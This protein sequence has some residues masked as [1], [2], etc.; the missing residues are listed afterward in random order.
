MTPS[1]KFVTD[2]CENTFL[3]FWSFPNPIGKRID[4]EL[5]DILVICDP[6]III[7]SV[8][9]I[10]VKE[11]GNVGVDHQ[12]WERNAIQE[13]VKQI[14]GAERFL[15]QKEDILLKDRIT[16]IKLPEK[17]IRNIYRV[18][19]AFGR[20][21]KFSLKMGD[22]GK[23][24]VHVFDERS[25]PIILQELDTITDF[26]DFLKAKEEFANK[27]IYHIAFSG[28]DYLAMY[29][30]NGFDMPDDVNLILIDSDYWIDYSKSDEYLTEKELNKISYI[31]DNLI[32]SLHF[33]FKNN[34]LI[35]STNRDELELT[36]RY[37]NKED[38]FGR[39]Q[40]CKLLV[41]VIGDEQTKP[42]IKARIVYSQLEGAKTLY[43]IMTRPD[44]DREFGNKELQLRC[45]V[46]RSLFKD[47][48]IVI[49]I[50]MDSF[51]K[52][53]GYSTDFVYMDFTNWSE[54]LQKQAEAIKEDLGYFK[55]PK[56]TVIKTDGNKQHP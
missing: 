25:L 1:E 44:N 7:F 27:N 8:K 55:T 42:T 29:L 34:L 46:A 20:G 43:L 32:Q 49:G 17:G 11:S 54:E 16:K 23:G 3:N 37:M 39:R 56:T 9:E 48:S 13:S 31:W 40:M 38:R 35:T 36:L 21:E 10:F 14:Y 33:D 19:V 24:Y 2:L 50:G 41:E 4:K 15:A 52:G 30:S 51:Q 18:A 28:E 45:L 12:R 22:F 5:C 26:I 47:R 53:K 6:D